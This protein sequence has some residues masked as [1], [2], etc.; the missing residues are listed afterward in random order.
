VVDKMKNKQASILIILSI[1][2]V[3]FAGM[4]LGAPSDYTSCSTCA[5]LYGWCASG[6][7][8]CLAGTSTGPS[9]GVA[10]GSWIW[11][12][13]QCPAITV[14]APTLGTFQN[15]GT[16]TVSWTVVDPSGTQVSMTKFYVG[17]KTST[18]SGVGAVSGFGASNIL[19]NQAACT[20]DTSCTYS[21]PFPT[22]TAWGSATTGYVV[23]V[24]YNLEGAQLIAEYSPALST[25]VTPPTCSASSTLSS[26][27]T[28]FAV[29]NC[30]V[31][32]Q[33][34]VPSTCVA[35]N[36]VSAKYCAAGVCQSQNL[37]CND[38]ISGTSIYRNA[39]CVSGKCQCAAGYTVVNDGAGKQIGC[40]PPASQTCSDGTAYGACSSVT[41]SKKCVSGT[42]V[43][44][45]VDCGCPS[46]G[47]TVCNAITSACQA[48]SQFCSDGTAYGACNVSKQ[49]LM[50]SLSGQLINNCTKCN[51]LSTGMT[52]CNSTTLNC[53]APPSGSSSELKLFKLR[54][55]I[56]YDFYKAGYL[57]CQDAKT[58]DSGYSDG[59]ALPV[60]AEYVVGI[61]NATV[62]TKCKSGSCIFEVYL[63]DK[64]THS[65]SEQ[66]SNAGITCL[67][68]AEGLAFAL[69]GNY[70]TGITNHT[71][72]VKVY[73]ESAK[74]N[75]IYEGTISFTLDES[76][77]ADGK[78]KPSEFCGWCYTKPDGAQGCIGTADFPYKCTELCGT[79]G[80]CGSHCNRAGWNE[81]TRPG[82]LGEPCVGPGD[83]WKSYNVSTTCYSSGTCTN[84]ICTFSAPCTMKSGDICS[85]TEGCYGGEGTRLACEP[86]LKIMGESCTNVNDCCTAYTSYDAASPT[87][88]E[89]NVLGECYGAEG[90]KV[91]AYSGSPLL[92]GY[93][94]TAGGCT[95]G[96]EPAPTCPAG[97]GSCKPTCVAGSE[98][99]DNAY[100]CPTAGQTCCKPST[101]NCVSAGI[102]TCRTTCAAG[103]TQDTSYACTSGGI[104]C[105][106]G[107][108]STCSLINNNQTCYPATVCPT[109]T[110]LGTGSCSFGV[111]CLSTGTTYTCNQ[112]AG[113]T[114]DSGTTCV[115]GK[116]LVSAETCASGT[117][118]CKPIS[119]S[120]TCLN[121]ALQTCDIGASCASGKTYGSGTCQTGQTCCKAINPSY[122]C[123]NTA[124]QFC[125]SPCLSNE[126]SVFGTCETG[127]CC[128]PK[129]CIVQ[130]QNWD[131]TE[132]GCCARE[133]QCLVSA[134][135]DAS[136]N[137]NTSAYFGASAGPKCIS[138][139]QFI[140]DHYCSNGNWISRTALIAGTLLNFTYA[141]SERSSDF[142]LLCDA[143][144]NA[145]NYVDYA[146]VL[147]YFSKRCYV[148]SKEVPC[149]NNVCVLR[150]KSGA[151]YKVIA[152]TA[153]NWEV[154]NASQIPFMSSIGK[155]E[156]YCNSALS[157]TDYS[158]CSGSDVWYN[159]SIDAVIFSNSAFSLNPTFIE[160]LIN[161]LKNPF[162]AI[163]NWLNRQSPEVEISNSN[164]EKMYSA[165]KEMKSVSAF[166]LNENRKSN[167]FMNF[168]GFSTDLCAESEKF[169]PG[170]CA[171]AKKCDQ[172]INS[173]VAAGSTNKLFDS[174]QEMTAGL[175]IN[176]SFSDH[177]NNCIKDS[178]E[179]A[180]DCGGND[181]SACVCSDFDSDGDGY[182]SDSAL[183]GCNVGDC[184]DNNAAVYPG[185]TEICDG[186]DNNCDGVADEG[187]S[188]TLTMQVTAPTADAL[189]V[190]GSLFTIRWNLSSPLLADTFDIILSTDNGMSYSENIMLLLQK[191]SVCNGAECAYSWTV[192]NS[193]SEQAKIKIDARKDG[194]LKASAYSEKFI[195]GPIAQLSILIT[196]PK[197]TD[198]FYIGETNTITWSA[199]GV[200]IG[201]VAKYAVH[202]SNG[203]ST[204]AWTLLGYSTSA[205]RIYSWAIPQTLSEGK[206]YV[207]VEARGADDSVIKSA[208]SEEFNTIIRKKTCAAYTIGTCSGTTCSITPY[209]AAEVPFWTACTSASG[210]TDNIGCGALQCT[211]PGYQCIISTTTSTTTQTS[212]GGFSRI[213]LGSMSES[214]CTEQGDVFD[215]TQYSPPTGTC[216]GLIERASY[217]TTSTSQS[218][219]P[220]P[221]GCVDVSD[222]SCSANYRCIFCQADVC[223]A[224]CSGKQCGTFSGC[225]CGTCTSGKTCDA[226]GICQSGGGCGA[227]SLSCPTGT[228]TSGT[229][230]N[231]VCSGG[232]TGY[233]GDGSCNNGETRTSCPA[234]CGTG[235]CTDTCASLG[236][237]CGT[238]CGQSCGTCTSGSCVNGGCSGG[239]GTYV[240][241][242]TS[243]DTTCTEVT[244]GTD[245][246]GKTCYGTKTGS[247]PTSCD[248]VCS[249]DTCGNDGCGKTCYGTK[250]CPVDLCAGVTCGGSCTSC[251]PST[252]S[253]DYKCG[254]MICCSNSGSCANDPCG[255]PDAPCECTCSCGCPA[256]TFGR[257]CDPCTGTCKSGAVFQ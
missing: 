136:L 21:L 166:T 124:N 91:C 187:C 3:L 183:S 5:S 129:T 66:Y 61:K 27:V 118:C 128:K 241:C 121:T 213:P 46:T 165:V 127:F 155:A 150:Y 26:G 194:A 72:K 43:D 28:R 218:N 104:C 143:Y 202:F 74:T 1:F 151:S 82:V 229:C 102:G 164:F 110:T 142:T 230:V 30:I 204:I 94:C 113:H 24:G 199:E 84:N 56:P 112:T 233:C 12:A 209:P 221:S 116:E 195:I 101:A 76:N 225:N 246:D 79:L 217:D 14:T 92:E 203:G 67:Y 200:E 257:V 99:A 50:C 154:N 108:T 77:N 122:T 13:S 51:C 87:K 201:T 149:L 38:T 78:C 70:F 215:A 52:A 62:S 86:P 153:L 25:G 226:A 88:T 161:I 210:C 220:T 105:K 125:R 33:S 160:S 103:E 205:E 244:C 236:Y 39:T 65:I 138:S 253:C 181:C 132:S 170:S 196:K 115:S 250:D 57:Q 10:C 174:W 238:V 239:G 193:K 9:G 45:C 85:P 173:T 234:D 139:G 189:L 53:Y 54:Q 177:C 64:L 37:G 60:C 198:I 148:G 206:Y 117:V 252:G 48:A 42:L 71:V 144:S 156:T 16:G 120:Y 223:P 98:V 90:S 97:I 227:C 185:A 224:V 175:R 249:T 58:F 63:N 75:L 216:T 35:G 197:S 167:L 4:A 247:C 145:L 93:I 20:T 135:G 140:L 68:N 147:N 41:K 123:M 228:C 172:I 114:C 248:S 163:L 11:L 222:K 182:V 214:D 237:E 211:G 55:D 49:P 95:G 191:T 179:V 232:G 159:P 178:D 242:S 243:C 130:K 7:P 32:G 134:T 251:N 34:A 169:V 36:I 18:V 141:D 6:T 47:L 208:I 44:S 119:S 184:D 235:G 109:G 17:F 254:G 89:C 168:K 22:R 207:K 96:G 80:V 137:D 146:P 157:A 29:T 100:S 188:L 107:S 111:C 73:G 256:C 131:A 219:T 8:R 212:G 152:A 255:C 240:P 2:A 15:G 31:S 83:C 81:R 171:Q 245:S 162:K 176:S 231:G 126:E 190:S 59:A 133:E 158:S 192:T 23:V 19:R 69:P 106:V 180:I 186:I 40:A